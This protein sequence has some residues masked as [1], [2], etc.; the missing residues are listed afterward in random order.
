LIWVQSRE[1]GSS[2]SPEFIYEN[3]S[4]RGR[5]TAHRCVRTHAEK[6]V[7]FLVVGRDPGDESKGTQ[8]RP[9]V[10]WEPEPYKGGKGT[11]HEVAVPRD[12]PS[13]R[14]RRVLGLMK[15]SEEHG[16]GE[17]GWPDQGSG[18]DEPPPG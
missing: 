4:S 9:D 8:G 15:S 14:G 3:V 2:P 6:G 1:I 16:R 13:V 7:D 5:S 18:V 17:T 12:C 11:I 10:V